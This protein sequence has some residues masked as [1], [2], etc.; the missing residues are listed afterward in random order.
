M[1]CSPAIGCSERLLRNKVTRLVWKL[2]VC[3]QV[4]L[5]SAWQLELRPRPRISGPRYGSRATSVG[6]RESEGSSVKS[7]KSAGRCSSA[8]AAEPGTGSFLPVPPPSRAV[9]KEFR[10]LQIRPWDG[11]WERSSPAAIGLPG[12][13]LSQHQGNLPT[14]FGALTVTGDAVVGSAHGQPPTSGLLPVPIDT[15]DERLISTLV[16]LVDS[17]TTSTHG[18]ETCPWRLSPS[19]PSLPRSM[20]HCH[21]R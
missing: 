14:H 5:V 3:R 1:V 11:M 15:A 16:P 20:T 21:Y 6:R 13:P 17:G 4:D 19:S 18:G 9:G 7:G 10:P 12:C 8:T 2:L